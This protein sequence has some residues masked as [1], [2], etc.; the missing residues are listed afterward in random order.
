MTEKKQI[1]VLVVEDDPAHAAMLRRH[2]ERTGTMSMNLATTLHDARRAVAGTPP[3]IL[4]LDLNLPDGQALELLSEGELRFPVLIMTAH[5][6]EERAVEVLKAGAQDY[7]VKS[8]AAFERMPQMINQTLREWR[9]TRERQEAID[10]LRKNEARLRKLSLAVE[11]SPAVV[12]ITDLEG[13]IEY[14]NP[15]FSDV[16][17]Y[18]FSEVVGENPRFLQSGL[19]A[20]E[21]YQQLWAHLQAG[22]EWQGEFINKHKTGQLFWE[23]AKICPLRNEQGETTH[24]IG[25]K[26]DITDRKNYER[27]LEHL[28]TH[29]DL[30]GLA[31]RTLLKDRF[32]QAVA[33]ARRLQHKVAIILLDLDRFKLINDSYGHDLGDELLCLVAA[34]LQ[35]TVR[36]TDT[37]ARFGGDEFVV[38]LETV[39]GADS[40]WAIATKLLQAIN[41]PYPLAGRSLTV[42]ASLGLS[43]APDDSDDAISLIRNAD[44]AMYQAKQRK[45]DIAFYNEEMNRHL[46]EV[47]DLEEGLR[48]A[49]ARHELLLYYQPKVDLRS[50]CITGCEALLRW[51]HP[52]RGMVSPGQFIPLAEETGLIVPI[53]AWVLQEACRQNMA[54]QAEGLAPLLMSVNL[55]ARQFQAGTLATE[56][57]TILEQ[58]GMPAELL[59]LELTESITMEDPDHAQQILQ[60]LKGLGI[61]LSLDDFGTGYSS[62]IYLSRFPFNHLKIDQNFVQNMAQ[63]SSATD[64]LKGIIDIAHTLNLTAIAEGVETREQLKIL[65]DHGCDMLQGY[66]FSK[67]LPPA[68]FARLLRA[69]TSLEHVLEEGQ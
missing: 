46:N 63:E 24:Y 30:T 14:V 58:S 10:E 39:D 45:Q 53:G 18:S 43:L 23:R 44:I 59:D 5:G 37:V 34:R 2:I 68:D 27:Q 41:Q 60:T 8:A 22:K 49:L 25:V 3:D 61:S 50:G 42:T 4:L 28:A 20:Q 69:G 31:N 26:E 21:S 36:E 57:Q 29:D 9:I 55:S 66:L 38:L 33:H 19:V 12:M 11:Q 16:T 15:K 32:A 65:S 40:A 7:L 6:S 17:G 1:R 48:Q 64:L 62:L 67:P 35:A 56:V 51:Q 52:Q 13:T 47:V 54:W